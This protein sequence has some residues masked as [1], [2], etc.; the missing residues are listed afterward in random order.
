MK[1]LH[2]PVGYSA[3]AVSSTR[4]N[5]A[6][7]GNELPLE[8]KKMMMQSALKTLWRAILWNHT[9]DSKSDI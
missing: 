3:I 1:N 8:I 4:I 6:K 9:P 5:G 7:M 2:V